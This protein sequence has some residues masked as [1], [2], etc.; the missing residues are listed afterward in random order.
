M[1][2]GKVIFYRIGFIAGMLLV[3]PP[4]AE[5]IVIRHDVLDQTYIDFGAEF[6]SVGRLT[7]N[8]NTGSGVLIARS[9]VL[10]AAHLKSG[11]S[12][13]GTFLLGGVPYAVETFYAH[14]DWTGD[15]LDGNDLALVRLAQPVT[16]TA[17][18]AWYTGNE[19]VGRIG[20]SVG[21][22]RTGT[23]LTGQISSSGTKRAGESL[24]ETIGT[25][26][27]FTPDLPPDDTLEYRFYDPGDPNVLPL[28]AMAAQGD[29]GG[30]VFIESDG[31][32]LIAGIHSFLWNM[33]GG[34]L[35]TY[36]DV[37]VSTRVAAYD[38]WIMGVIPEP[39]TVALW[40]GAAAWLLAAGFRR[41]KRP[42]R[43]GND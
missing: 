20:V 3:P 2:D 13:P 28:E 5:A 1:N 22:G 36:G 24:L 33:N 40:A 17:P 29:S 8:T 31:A 37:V 38:E 21:Y 41:R 35:A 43:Q 7:S 15:V 27:P 16:Q 12:V 10:T 25:R 6:S 26:S 11:S 34:N 30:P 19:E 23:G 18:S 42:L 39:G 4:A 14:P 9:W 32:F